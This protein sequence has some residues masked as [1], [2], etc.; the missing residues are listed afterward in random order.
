MDDLTIKEMQKMQKQLWEIHKNEW[1]PMS[2]TYGKNFILWMISEVGEVIDIIKKKGDDEVMKSESVREKFIEE[3]C[4]VLM[5]FNDILL[6]Y[7]ITP[8][9]FVAG[10]RY[11]HEKNM[12]RKY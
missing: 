10:Y 3:L 2:A 8:D 4:D 9:E 5:Y 11:K 1:S 6:R 12:T 7:E